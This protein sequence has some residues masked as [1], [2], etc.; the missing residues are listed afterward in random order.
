MSNNSEHD[1]WLPRQGG[2][3]RRGKQASPP[4]VTED[5]LVLT[6]LREQ[7]RR[8]PEGT[9]DSEPLLPAEKSD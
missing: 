3:R 7:Q 6:D 1:F 4:F 5:G 2:E 8:H 9:P